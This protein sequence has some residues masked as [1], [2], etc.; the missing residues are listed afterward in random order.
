MGKG[1]RTKELTAR[2][3]ARL[4]AANTE[5]EARRKSLF[6]KLGIVG[7]I[8]AIIAIVA[9]VIIG[10]QRAGGEDFNNAGQPAVAKDMGVIVGEGRKIV[11]ETPEGVS[12]VTIY[13]DYICPG[14]KAFE[15]SYAEEI[16]KIID[17]G[18]GTIEYRSIGMLDMTS[19]G[20][21][22]S[23]RAANAALCAAVEQP[24]KFYPF[25]KLLYANQPA[26]G[27][28]GLSNN[29]LTQLAGSMG[30]ENIESCVDG[31]DYR[32]FVKN[33]TEYAIGE[34]QIEG[35]PTILINGE[36]IELGGSLYDEVIKANE[37]LDEKPASD[38]ASPS[39]SES[40]SGE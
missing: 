23:S 34:E 22:Y 6:I 10:G 19:M 24:D 9:A 30:I 4:T 39:A 35:T 18:V 7:G 27:T 28:K 40:A 3:K 32:G 36:K 16:D 15:Q 14:C 1:S 33:V 11:E 38:S 5:K 8:I 21:N 12:N 31:G 26:E 37:T 17:E 25:N 13:Q 2:E 20:T 29:Q